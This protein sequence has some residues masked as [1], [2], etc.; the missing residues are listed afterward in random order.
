MSGVTGRMD[1]ASGA[2]GA[3]A[4]AASPSAV[5]TPAFRRLTTE[6]ELKRKRFVAERKASNPLYYGDYLQLDKVCVVC[7]VPHTT[8][9]AGHISLPH[10]FFLLV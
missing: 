7:L 5:T 3:G 8:A 10:L 4:G 1:A 9:R 6:E 2:G